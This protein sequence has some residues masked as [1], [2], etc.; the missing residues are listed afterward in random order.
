METKKMT[1]LSWSLTGVLVA[2]IVL[3][4]VV[5]YKNQNKIEMLNLKNAGLISTIEERDSLVNELATTFDE[6]EQNLTFVRD[7]RGNMT[8][9]GR[10]G[11]K[12]EKEVLVADIKL[13]NEML[14]ESSVK[15]EEL[16]K[17]LKASGIEIKSFRN[18]I[19]QLN[20][21]IEEQ[22]ASIMQLTAE[23]EQRD[24]KIAEM[25]GTI[26][27]LKK[28]LALRDD[29]IQSKS[30]LIAQK[31]QTIYER[32]NELNKAYFAAGTKKQLIE[33]GV[34]ST[35]GG[36]LGIAKN[37][38][39]KDDFN[40]GSFTQLDM[41]NASQFPINAKK[42]KLISEHPA[43]SYKLVEENNKIAYLEIENPQEFWKLSRYVI[44]ETRN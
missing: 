3:V 43:S 4:S 22:N 38:S 31:S 44:V 13:M 32:E 37:K 12:N 20:K 14:E 29:T 5:S 23:L 27:T 40:P 28:D 8:I 42:A 9:A 30:Q 35:D 17:K 2:L 25:D 1:V 11:A 16:E 34:I 10:E 24:Y 39:I 19:A 36:F 21:S 15:I 26:V 41:R 7:K 18:K 33:K 6:I